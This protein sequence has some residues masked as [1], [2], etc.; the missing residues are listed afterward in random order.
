MSVLSGG[1]GVRWGVSA[2]PGD[3]LP[4]E[5]AGD[6]RLKGKSYKRTFVV[7]S[8]ISSSIFQ[9]YGELQRLDV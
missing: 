4:R 6:E 1:R 7:G 3:R 5:L 8:R 9:L 2:G